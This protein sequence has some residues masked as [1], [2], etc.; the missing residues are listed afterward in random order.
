MSLIELEEIMD[1]GESYIYYFRGLR[2]VRFRELPEEL[3][4]K[5]LMSKVGM[6][7]ATTDGKIMVTLIDV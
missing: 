1:V 6:I 2:N 5:A 7:D 3:K 4:R